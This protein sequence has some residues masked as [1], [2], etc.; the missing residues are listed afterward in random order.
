MKI[1]PATFRKR[2][3]FFNDAVETL[4]FILDNAGK[5]IKVFRF[6]SIGR[7]KVSVE[8]LSGNTD[9]V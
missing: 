7:S 3:E 6:F 1:Q 5:I 8:P 9:G 2:Q 4:D